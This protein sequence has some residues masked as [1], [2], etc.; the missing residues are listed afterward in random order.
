MRSVLTVLMV[1]EDDS[2]QSNQMHCEAVGHAPQRCGITQRRGLDTLAQGQVSRGEHSGTHQVD[3]VKLIIHE[4]PAVV[5]GRLLEGE[6]RFEC[7]RSLRG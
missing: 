5:S 4:L 3:V 7:L 6:K 2:K 1:H